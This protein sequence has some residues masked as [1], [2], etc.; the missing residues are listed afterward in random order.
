M[1]HKSVVAEDIGKMKLNELERQKL[2]RDSWQ[3]AEHVKLYI[4]R[5]T[6]DK[7]KGTFISSGFSAMEHKGLP[8]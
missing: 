1:T 2:A 8:R 7:K 5:P 3:Q 6:E 4:F